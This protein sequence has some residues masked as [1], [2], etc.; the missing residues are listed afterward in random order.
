MGGLPSATGEE[1]LW[2]SGLTG[3][4]TRTHYGKG[5]CGADGNRAPCG[6]LL[7][8][9]GHLH[10]RHRG[11]PAVVDI[12]FD[13]LS[14][15]RDSLDRALEL[16]AW[17]DQQHDARRLKQAIQSV[18]H[19]IEL[20]LK[21]RLRRLHPSL[22]WEQV[23]RYPNL[24][25]RT[26]GTELA[27]TRL[28]SIGSVSFLAADLELLRSLR[29]TRNAIEHFAWTTT[30]QEA[31]AIV[32]RALEFAFHFASAELEVNYLDY[33]AH[34]DGTFSDLVASSP[35]FRRAHERRTASASPAEQPIPLVCSV[36]RGKAVD[37]ATRGCRLCGHWEPE[38]Y[39]DDDIPF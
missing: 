17:G 29:A 39:P 3:R 25:A 24:N 32:G 10:V 37:P 16:V 27:A 31:D 1:R 35:D 8:R 30:K 5:P 34:R 21:E 6:A 18:A 14:N 12:K 33:A 2:V 36:C 26:V 38:Q 13:L 28:Q 23:D 9:A 22:I 20:L 7:K 4:S 11:E 19:S 15:A